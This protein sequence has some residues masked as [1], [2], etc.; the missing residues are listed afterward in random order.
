MIRLYNLGPFNQLSSVS[1]LYIVSLGMFVQVLAQNRET[2][3]TLP[4]IIFHYS[5]RKK[6]ERKERIDYSFH[7]VSRL[8]YALT[9]P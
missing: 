3:M 4:S 6:Y 8:V 9:A 2:V 1:F 7:L 5:K